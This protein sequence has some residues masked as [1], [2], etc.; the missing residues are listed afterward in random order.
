MSLNL[1]KVI[2]AGRITADPELKQTPSGVSLVTF[3]LA[4]NRRFGSRDGQNQQP[5]ADFF[6][7]TAWRNTAEFIAKYFRKGSAI[8]ICGSIQN[9]SWTDQ[10][11]QKRY[12][13]DII[14]EE[15]NFVESRNTQDGQANYGA[16][17]AYSAPAY[18]SPAQVNA[19]KFEEIKTDDDLPF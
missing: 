19:P 1:N 6:R 5:E 3:S 10:N 13:T 4:V 12:V 8:C 9:R 18:S 17:D 14:A 16:T 7:I 11:G 2:L 15:A